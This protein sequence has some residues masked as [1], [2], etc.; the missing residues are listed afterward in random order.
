MLV[1]VALAVYSMPVADSG[2]NTKLLMVVSQVKA[3]ACARVVGVPSIL[4]I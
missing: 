1:M 2:T 3:V 4:R